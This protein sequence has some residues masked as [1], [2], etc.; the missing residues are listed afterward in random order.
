MIYDAF[1][2]DVCSLDTGGVL[3][4]VSEHDSLE[5]FELVGVKVLLHDLIVAHG[6][7]KLSLIHI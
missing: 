7:L 2:L 5:E 6:D 4:D 1:S 3:L